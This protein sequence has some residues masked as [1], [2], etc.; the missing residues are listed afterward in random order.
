MA[1]KVASILAEIGIDSSKFTSGAGSIG[2]VV[3]G[4]INTIG[5]MN[6]VI[7]VAASALAG[8]TAYMGEAEK[9]AAGVAEGNAK[10]QAILSATG[11]A[12]GMTATQLDDLANSL[13]QMSGIDDDVI[14]SSESMMLT[15]RNIGRDA[16]PQA[17]QAAL[18][19]QTTFG[20]LE[21][22]TMQLGKALNDPVAGITALNR[23]G[24]TFSDSQKQQIKNFVETNQLA[25]AQAIILKEVSNQV[26]GTSAAIE[27]AGD[28]SN[29][30]KIAQ[31]N[32]SEAIG[33]RLV[34]AQRAWNNLLADGYDAI[35]KNVEA[36]N[37]YANATAQVASTYR[38][39]NEAMTTG[40]GMHTRLTDQAQ[41]DIDATL[42]A[43]EMG[44]NWEETLRAQGVEFEGNTSKIKAHTDATT[45]DTQAAADA[46]KTYADLLSASERLSGMDDSLA[47]S[48][49]SLNAQRAKEATDLQTAVYWWGTNS[50]AA[51][52]HRQKLAEIDAKISETSANYVQALEKMAYETSVKKI[53]MSDG[54]AGM[55]D[56][57]FAMAQALGVQM[58]VFSAADAKMATDVN[59]LSSMLADGKITVEQFG[60]AINML[61]DGKNINVILDILR[62]E[63]PATSPNAQVGGSTNTQTGQGAASA[64]LAGN[65]R[66]AGGPAM[67]RTLVGENGPEI[68]DLPGG[69]FVNNNGT[70]KAML[71]GGQTDNGA[72]AAAIQNL[73]DRFDTLRAEFTALPRAFGAELQRVGI[74]Q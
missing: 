20:S 26:G 39:T 63:A 73:A 30:L 64:W 1:T 51:D 16:F 55:S 72:M 49:A 36:S 32:L 54:V 50:Q 13:S 4:L 10:M 11:Y 61:P 57:E 56:A 37:N 27:K 2:G 15:F 71:S 25:Q 17:M 6:P 24:V 66:A 29:R 7:G 53:E 22:S 62:N 28:G 33:Q 5:G 67:G 68:V 65:Q 9:A 44:K 12:A 60:K 46:S 42:R 48:M 18:D 31:D 52:E 19:L 35:T 69:S 38:E 14:K 40:L 70:S 23:A 47:Q 21:S 3:S 8:L 45:T 58:G 41:N 59:T 74:G 34:P 43:T